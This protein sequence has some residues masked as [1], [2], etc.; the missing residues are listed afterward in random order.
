MLSLIFVVAF[1]PYLVPSGSMWPTL[2]FK[3]VIEADPF[4]IGTELPK[5]GEIFVFHPPAAATFLQPESLR[6]DPHFFFIKRCVG[7]AGEVIEIRA[8]VLYRNGKAVRPNPYQHYSIAISA[9]EFGE[10]P[11]SLLRA[12]PHASFKW[13]KWKIHG[14]ETLIPLNYTPTE[15]NAAVSGYENAYEIA[16]DFVIQDPAQQ[17]QARRLPPQPI[18]EGYVMM[19]GDNWN[20]SFDSRGWGLLRIDAIVGKYNPSKKT[21]AARVS[22]LGPI[23]HAPTGHTTNHVVARA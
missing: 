19:M 7:T 3:S 9:T 10:M 16:P 8:G 20:N 6:K 17:K 11:K 21:G 23:P 18:P 2:K 12:V 13:V 14:K 5:D 15:A 1:K 22:R 4:P